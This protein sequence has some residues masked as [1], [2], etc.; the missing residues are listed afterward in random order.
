MTSNEKFQFGNL[1]VTTKAGPPS[2]STRRTRSL[3][4]SCLSIPDLSL[5]ETL[6]EPSF[7][8]SCKH[9]VLKVE[10]HSCPDVSGTHKSGTAV[11]WMA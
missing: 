9:H 3:S 10:L 4:N 11:N 1:Y 2:D 7:S 5:A 6:T 8:F